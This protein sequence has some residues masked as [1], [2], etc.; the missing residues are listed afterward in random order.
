MVPANSAQ[1]IV[2]LKE[3]A[4]FTGGASKATIWRWIAEGRFPKPIKIGPN[5]SGWVEGEIAAWQQA[6]IAERDRVHA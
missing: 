2:K 5:S 4:P 3:L 6:R 1:R